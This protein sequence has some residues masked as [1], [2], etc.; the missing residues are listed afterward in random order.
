MK[1]CLTTGKITLADVMG[2]TAILKAM[3]SNEDD[4]VA[5]HDRARNHD[6][7]IQKLRD[8]FEHALMDEKRH[9]TWMEKTV[10]ARAAD[11]RVTEPMALSIRRR[12]RPNNPVIRPRPSPRTPRA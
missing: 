11:P 12:R 2:D 6:D 8:F 4:T 9:R 5:A 3:L 7:A 10:Q 1:Q